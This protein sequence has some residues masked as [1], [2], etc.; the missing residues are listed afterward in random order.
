M[1]LVLVC[2]T[3]LEWASQTNLPAETTLKLQSKPMSCRQSLCLSLCSCKGILTSFHHFCMIVMCQYSLKRH[4][5]Q[6][7]FFFFYSL[8]FSCDG[9]HLYTANSDGTVIAW[10]RKD[11]QRLKQPMFYSFLSS[12]AAGW[13]RGASHFQSSVPP[14]WT[15]RLRLFQEGD[16]EDT[17]DQ[18]NHPSNDKDC[19]SAQNSAAVQG[20]ERKVLLWFTDNL[21][22]RISMR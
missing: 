8:T 16:P 19:S 5:V 3:W 13:M 9:H 18:T 6:M 15:C 22:G 4:N 14:S 1:Y 11:Q 17:D 10:C 20:P 21:E 12:Y 7:G 2:I